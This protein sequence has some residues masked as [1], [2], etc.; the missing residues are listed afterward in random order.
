MQPILE[1]YE[2]ILFNVK[3]RLINAVNLRVKVSE[4]KVCSLLSGGLD[5]SLIAAIAAKYFEPYTFETFSIGLKGSP[6]LEAAKRVA[7][8]IKSN[9]TTIIVSED[10]FLAAIPR[11]IRAIESYDT[12]SVRASVGNFLVA[13]HIRSQTDNKVV[14]NGDYADEVC[15]GYIYLKKAP[16]LEMFDMECKKLVQNINYFDSL[17]SDRSI[18]YHGLEAR[19][20]FSDKDFV[21]Y[22]F[23]IPTQYRATTTEKKILRDAF[24]EFL[25]D[26]ILWRPKEAFSDGVSSQ[27][28]SWSTI[29]QE[30]VDSQVSDLEFYTSTFS[31]NKPVLKET[32]YYRKIF[33]SIFDN[34]H[35]I[36]YYW[37]PN[38]CD[39]D[40]PSARVLSH[41]KN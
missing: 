16:S 38:W 22:Y 26:D 18:S 41:Y 7:D 32:Y 4:K 15:G 31:Y 24:Q 11:V 20:P 34:D 19:T 21:E 9:H 36:P 27:C 17:R 25:P 37:L 33:N 29:I 2:T 35:V 40:D 12:T 23:G 8:F 6:D 5:S 14:L 30:Y 1:S 39:V 13:E 28:R 3:Q 10:D